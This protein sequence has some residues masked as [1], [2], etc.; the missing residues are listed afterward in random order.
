MNLDGM[1]SSHTNPHLLAL[2]N[3]INPTMEAA[4][5]IPHTTTIGKNGNI[6][7]TEMHRI[8]NS[9]NAAGIMNLVNI[10]HIKS[11]V[12][13]YMSWFGSIYCY[14]AGIAGFL[15]DQW[16]FLQTEDNRDNRG[17]EGNTSSARPK[18]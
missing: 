13:S 11:Y 17:S 1:R 6:I 9:A 15:E 2:C 4:A 12:R 3:A 14:K 10:H 5:P 18:Q 8:R 7:N 16:F